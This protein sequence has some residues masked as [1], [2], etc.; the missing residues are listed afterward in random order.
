MHA[1]IRKLNLKA[2]GTIETPLL[3]PSFSS[4]ALQNESVTQI[5]QYMAQTISDEVLIS[6]Y[7]L[8][9]HRVK[10]KKIASFASAV[11]LDSG[12]YEATKDLDLSDV[13]DKEYRPRPWR[14]KQLDQT[15]TEAWDFGFPTV[16]VSYDSPHA[17]AKIDRQISRAKKLFKRSPGANSELLLK[18]ESKKQAHLNID[19]VISHKHD[20]A[21]FDIIGVTE[22]E[23]GK[24]TLERMTNIAKLRQALTSVD[25]HS[26]IHI[27]GSLD[28]V[29]SPLYFMAGADIFDGLTW[30][31]YAF[32]EGYTLY[33]HDYGAK[34]LGISLED[35]RVN[36]MTW[37][38]NLRYL[39]KM[40]EDMRKFLLKWD[41][42]EF[43]NN[44]PL[45]KA[46]NTEFEAKLRELS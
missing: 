24:S 22:K 16:L 13:G 3:L 30:L 41:F 40:K 12:G 19:E 32:H 7:D 5:I 42:D 11:F 26:P 39:F 38:D 17:K 45:F 10:Y 43:R 35:F 36:G 21:A 14:Q 37:N 9:Y 2:G 46:L 4:K 33:K 25:C 28:T 20:L 31:R 6:A 8:H 34:N 18:T 1:K 29:S 23:L 44:G 27:F 15:L